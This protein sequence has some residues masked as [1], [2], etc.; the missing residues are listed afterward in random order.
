MH[1]EPD[2]DGLYDDNHDLSESKYDPY[3]P[4]YPIREGITMGICIVVVVAIIVWLLT[5]VL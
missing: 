3:L 4:L 2:D 1:E 5:K